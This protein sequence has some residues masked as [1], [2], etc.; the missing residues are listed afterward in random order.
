MNKVVAIVGM[1]GSGKSEVAKILES[2]GFIRVRFGDITDQEIKK[3]GLALNEDNERHIREIL[4]KELGMAAY[5]I[6]NHS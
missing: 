6:L 2:K 4:R 1:A 5:A 3:R